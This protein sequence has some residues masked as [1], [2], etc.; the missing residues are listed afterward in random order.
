[1]VAVMLLSVA[2]V[3]AQGG[4]T[5]PLTWNISDSTLTI[6]GEGAMP[7]YILTSAPW[8]PHR[9][10]ITTVVIENGVTSIG[11]YAFR[12]CELMTS[13]A[14]P[15]GVIR[16][17]HD[18]FWRCHALTSVIIPD[19]VTS[20]SDHTFYECMAL[21]TIVIPNSVEV[22]ENRAFY[23]CWSLTSITLPNNLISIEDEAFAACWA[24]TSITIPS[25]VTNIG[26]SVFD[27]CGD[28]T[29]IDVEN[30]NAHYSSDNGV[31]FNK[32]KTTLI[33]CPIRKTGSYIIPNGVKTIGYEAFFYCHNLTEIS[34]P[35]SVTHIEIRAFSS[36]QDITSINIPSSVKTIESWAFSGCSSLTSIEIP[37]S[38]TNIEYGTFEDCGFISVTIPNS[39]ISV[40]EDAFAGCYNLALIEIPNSVTSIGNGAFSNCG[41]ISVALPSSIKSIGKNAFIGCTKLTSIVIPDGVTTIGE[42]AFAY[43]S[44]LALVTL[45]SSITKIENYIFYRCYALSSV[46]NLKTQPLLIYPEV[47]YNVNLSTRTLKVPASAVTNY[48]KTAVWKEFNIIGGDYLVKV[49]ANN[50]EYGYVT[51]YE[52]HEANATATVAATAYKGYKF[53]NWTKDGIAVS[54][55]NPYSFTVTEDVELVATFEEDETGIDTVEASVAKIYPNPTEG[56]LQVTSYELPIEEIVIWD[57]MGRNVLSQKAEGEKQKELDISYLPAGMYF[58]QV[59]TDKGVVTRKV[60]KR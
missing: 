44:S 39:V 49:S 8:F 21:T 40:G 36:C 27:F 12:D 22:I 20:I 9:H 53:V 51:G 17:G 24:L 38:I 34:L 2:G 3:F 46:T 35:N 30:E 23:F 48:Q 11:N 56:K 45:P 19:G 4:T 10:F 26:I 32:N 28:L 15:H 29:S 50:V 55:D 54:A 18:A 58:V 33:R 42:G 60:V 5:G 13:I 47:F 37:N 43:C 41:V 7:D 52:L 14:I 57:I 59:Q 1:M 6:S 16:I 25:S 31:L